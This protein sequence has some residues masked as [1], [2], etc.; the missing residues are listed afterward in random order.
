[1]SAIDLIPLPAV[2]PQ[3][4]NANTNTSAR[5]VRKEGTGKISVPIKSYHDVLGSRPKYLRYNLWNPD[6]HF[7]PTVT[8]WS[9]TV[10]P[11]P[12]PPLSEINDPIACKTIAENPSLFKIVSP[13]NVDQF[14]ELLSDHPNP[15]FVQSM[16]TGLREGFWPW[17]D[18][19][20]DGYPSTYDA[21]CPTP[22]DNKKAQ[23]I[24]D[25]H[26]I[27]LNKDRFSPS[28]G[29][30]LL[31]GMY[32]MPVHAVPKPNS[33]DLRMV[34]DHSAGPFSLNSMINYSLVTRYPLDNMTHIGEMLLAHH[35][36]MHQE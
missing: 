12:C 26:D 10:I 32:C 27:E 7:T 3:I 25:Q 28:F 20:K 4:P 6:S 16:C 9:E 15:S 8:D 24:R 19:H 29:T 2:H 23:F 36:S 34:I 30:D 11:L 17:A 22:H 35:R 21:A 33:T 1:M 14:Q 31:P 18:T 13:I 5:I